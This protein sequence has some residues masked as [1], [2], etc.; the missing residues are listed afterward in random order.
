MVQPF[1]LLDS[2]LV[3]VVFIVD[4]IF[5]LQEGEDLTY[6]SARKQSGQ[7]AALLIVV[8]RLWR[9]QKI[10]QSIAEDAQAKVLHMLMICEKEKNHAE[11]KVDILI[12]K[13]EDL[14]HEVAYL[15]EKAKKCDKES[16]AA[17]HQ[18][19]L[20]YNR[21]PIAKRTG[22]NHSNNSSASISFCP[23]KKTGPSQSVSPREVSDE[24]LQLQP[25][26]QPVPIPNYTSNRAMSNQSTIV[27]VY[28][29]PTPE[30]L[31]HP[32]IPLST[33]TVNR[34]TIATN[35]D[36]NKFALTLAQNITCEV[37]NALLGNT[38]SCYQIS[39]AFPSVVEVRVADNSLL[40]HSISKDLRLNS[41]PDSSGDM[42]PALFSLQGKCSR[43]EPID[44]S[45]PAMIRG[46]K[47][48][49]LN[50]KL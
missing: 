27:H 32:S 4:L 23:C 2:I 21:K 36:L 43:N 28:S 45:S 26:P 35:I 18:I 20:V 15:K 7:E 1:E 40:N 31:D 19:S 3:F 38:K 6:E 29:P 42:K 10:I 16:A 17:L 30:E 34:P 8:L 9:I 12:L 5:F 50:R 39:Q 48:R 41:S 47:S 11:H 33:E 22:S 25:P 37:V 46:N 14:E 24:E 44:I 13:V 49:A